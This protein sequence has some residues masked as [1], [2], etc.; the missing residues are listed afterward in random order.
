MQT[1]PTQHRQLTPADRALLKLDKLLK[2][3]SGPHVATR[4]Y[5]AADIPETVQDSATRHQIAGMMRVNHAGEICA[6]ALYH[7]QAATA[8]L[9]GVRDAMHQAAQEEVDHLAW[10]AQRLQELNDHPSRLDP[11][12]YAGSFAIGALAGISGDKRSLGFVAE[13]EKQV[14]AHLQKHLAQL[15]QDDARSRTVLEQMVRD[16][17]RH[18]EQALHQGGE[19]PPGPIQ[20]LMRLTAKLMT[21]T[22]QRF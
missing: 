9:E 13:T 4:P 1:T 5:P 3:A 7:G 18:G 16:E 20:T 12:W 6:Q 19:I 2:S 14:V 11:L 15:P 10:C 8:K 21:F 22:A 17:A